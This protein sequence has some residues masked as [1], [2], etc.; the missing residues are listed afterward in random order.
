MSIG[1]F[2][3]S[4]IMLSDKYLYVSLPYV[5]YHPSYAILDGYNT[6]KKKPSLTGSRFYAGSGTGS[7]ATLSLFDGWK[8]SLE[9]W[10]EDNSQHNIKCDARLIKSDG[11]LEFV[12]SNDATSII[13]RRESDT[14][15]I[16]WPT[17]TDT[18]GLGYMYDSE[19]PMGYPG[20]YPETFA[21]FALPLYYFFVEEGAWTEALYPQLIS[22][23]IIATYALG[24][25]GDPPEKYISSFYEYPSYVVPDGNGGT[26]N[27][28]PTDILNNIEDLAMQAHMS[29]SD[30][31]DPYPP[32]E[33]LTAL[34]AEVQ[35]IEYDDP[36]TFIIGFPKELFIKE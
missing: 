14:Y 28:T 24:E 11:S 8:L 7:P 26:Y 9:G 20:I 29:W 10:G 3:P 32:E 34:E 35:T 2:M 4:N 12:F 23:I 1:Q 19:Y 27:A 13:M 30:A 15:S 25:L 6:D 21:L 36:L 5:R 16:I 31:G 17:L 18:G 33:F 22:L